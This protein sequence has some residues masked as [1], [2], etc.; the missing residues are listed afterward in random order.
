MLNTGDMGK[1]KLQL[2]YLHV[3]K[4]SHDYGLEDKGLELCVSIVTGHT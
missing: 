2:K 1:S 4:T 3:A